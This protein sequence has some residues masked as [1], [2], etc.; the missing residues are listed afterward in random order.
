MAMLVVTRLCKA[1]TL[2]NVSILNQSQRFN[3]Y[4]TFTEGKD[5]ATRA[6]RRQ[7]LG[8]KEKLMTPAGDTGNNS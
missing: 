5:A 2:Q 7:K 8:I 4:R 1:P 3:V 6:A